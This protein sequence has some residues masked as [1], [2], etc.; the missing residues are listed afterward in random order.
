[1]R[2]HLLL[3]ACSLVPI[4]GGGSAWAQTTATVVGTVTDT[5]GAVAPNVSITVTSEGTGLTRKTLTNQS[6]YYAVTLLPVGVYSVTAEAAGF[7]KKTTTGIVLE[8]N[9]E[10]RVDIALE[11]GAL[12]D[13]VTVNAE[14]SVLQTENAV[15][16]QVVDTRYTT[17]IPLNGRD[18]SQLLLLAPGTT[19]LTSGIDLSVG[20][21]TGSNGSGIA[22]G[23]RD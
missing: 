13:A 22:I 16:G 6:G 5:S 18:F 9:Q 17:Q 8:V 7:K 10:P 23:G 11:V 3:L 20:S 19:T 4:A 12:T 2:I 1:M 21:A 14:A 15:V